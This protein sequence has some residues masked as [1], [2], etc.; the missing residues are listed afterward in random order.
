MSRS[1][2]RV[3]GSKPAPVKEVTA[4][5]DANDRRKVTVS[6]PP[7]EGASAY[8]VRY[9]IDARTLYQH[10]LVRGGRIG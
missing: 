5:R 6:W 1:R 9:G 2:L 3:E 10:D 7:S 4:Q 8:V